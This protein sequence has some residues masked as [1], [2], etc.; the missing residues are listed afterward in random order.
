MSKS[1]AVSIFGA[2]GEVGREV[3]AQLI[4]SPVVHTIH[5]FGRTPVAAD[6]KKVQTTTIDFEQL[7]INQPGEVA[8]VKQAADVVIVTLGTTRAVSTNE[9][10]YTKIDREFVVAAA[11]ASRVE[12]K[13]QTLLYCS[14]AG[15]SPNSYMFYP[16]TKGLTE[17]ELAA[18]GYDTTI[19]FRPAMLQVPGGRKERR[20]LE[21]F[22]S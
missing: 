16:R 12:G 13:K 6:N 8:K 11:R 7:L 21:A 10:V 17:Q 3:L 19:V 2:T 5:Q 9:A 1:F 4:A 18:I 20:S 15:A 14:S 22:A